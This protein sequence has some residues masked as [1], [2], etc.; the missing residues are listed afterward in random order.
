MSVMNGIQ[1]NDVTKIWDIE[2]EAYLERT[3]VSPRPLQWRPFGE[4]SRTVFPRFIGRG[5]CCQCVLVSAS[6]LPARLHQHV[7]TSSRV[8]CSTVPARHGR[9][10]P[11]LLRR[12]FGGQVNRPACR[13]G[14]RTGTLK[15]YIV[16]W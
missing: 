16:P 10:T 13:E 4:G 5:C 15:G 7:M 8:L 11:R 2:P 12:I 3:C 14:P 1:Q 9:Q 6:G